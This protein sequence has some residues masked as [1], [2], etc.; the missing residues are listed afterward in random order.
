MFLQCQLCLSQVR[1]AAVT[2]LTLMTAE[3]IEYL[4]HH[5]KSHW[6]L[7]H[8]YTLA[9]KMFSWSDTSKLLQEAVLY[10]GVT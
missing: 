4:R 9:H 5:L 3:D 10:V 6:V 2:R 8:G 1:T 7:P